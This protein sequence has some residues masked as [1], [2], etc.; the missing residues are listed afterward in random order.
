MPVVVKTAF[1]GV[2][3]ST[4][5]HLAA[6]S[7]LYYLAY[8][9]LP[10][11][12]TVKRKVA[13]LAACL[14]IVSPAGLFLSAPYGE[15]TFAMSNFASALCYTHAVQTKSR[16]DGNPAMIVIWTLLS[17][18]CIGL[19]TMVRSNGLLGGLVFAWDALSAVRHPISLIS[20]Y[21]AFTTFAATICAG[22]FVAIGFTAPQLVAFV[23]YCVAGN[24]RPWC[25]KAV[26]SIYSWVQSHYWEVGFLRYWTLNNLPLFLLAAPMLVL[27]LYTA[28]VA[29]TGPA[30]PSASQEKDEAAQKLAF[31]EWQVYKHVM[32][33][34][35]VQQLILAL[36][37]AT[38]FH[39]QIVNRISS[40]Y[41]VLYIVLA[42]AIHSSSESITFAKVVQTSTLRK[43]LQWIVRGMVMYAIVQGGLYASFLPPA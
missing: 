19:S 8:N 34:L 13:F 15:S 32:P 43:C 27:M 23:E 42:S 22:V 41:P 24:T 25:S 2:L 10:A 39:V 6:V 1:V 14:H 5:S 29:C 36:M 40:G 9:V 30:S 21:R 28:V 7:T 38:S 31:A 37:A 20:D 16:R 26:P 4:L 18:L 33:R 35:G 12:I 17:G 3:I 11:S